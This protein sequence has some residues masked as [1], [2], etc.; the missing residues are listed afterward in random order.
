MLRR[1]DGSSSEELGSRAV[2]GGAADADTLVVEAVGARLSVHL[3]SRPEIRVEVEDGRYPHG[4]VGLRVV[5]A[6]AVFARLA[7]EPLDEP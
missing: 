7:V 2:P 5:G 1:S 3:R 6:H 4:S